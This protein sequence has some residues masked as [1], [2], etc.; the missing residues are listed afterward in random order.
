MSLNK[1]FE[2]LINSIASMAE[3]QNP[4][5]KEDYVG[6]DGL[7]YCGKCHTPR[8]CS[9][10]WIDG[11]MRKMPVRCKCRV[12]E[13]KIEAERIKQLERIAA[14]KKL[15]VS[16]LMDEKFVECTFANIGENADNRRQIGICKRYVEKFRE[17]LAK[18]QGLL[19]YGNVGTGKTL[20]ACCIGNELMERLYPVFATSFIKILEQSKA[21]KGTEVD[22]DISRMNNADLL[23]ID[24]LGAERST[25]YALEIVY[26][27]ID[28]RYRAK[29][30]L[31]VTTNLNIYDMRS[32]VDTRYKRIY[33]RIFEMCYP[34][35]FTGKSW[36]TREAGNRFNEMKSLLEG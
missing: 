11:N 1:G 24:D 35:E 29:K 8:Q 25:D 36:R 28:S 20:L 4:Q 19:F 30:P 6:D 15:K 33:D 34:V 23:I 9:V 7:L 5:C 12:E 26:N 22:A 16:S 27:V 14:V 2:S 31:I 32:A 17:M 3:A 10:R 18:N 13:D 21:F